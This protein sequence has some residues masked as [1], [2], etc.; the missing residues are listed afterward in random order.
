MMTHL[1]TSARLIVALALPAASCTAASLQKG[2]AA[3]RDPNVPGATGHAVVIGSS[4]SMSGVDRVN[5][6]WG[7]AALNSNDRD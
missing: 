1:H 3:A 5:P 2:A 6:D 4:S 7:S